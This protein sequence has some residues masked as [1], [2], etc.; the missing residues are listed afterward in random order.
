ML[1]RRRDHA[2][3]GKGQQ[4]CEQDKPS[5]P[6]GIEMTAD[7]RRGAKSDAAHYRALFLNRPTIKQSCAFG[8]DIR[9]PAMAPPFVICCNVSRINPV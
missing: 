4:S 7:N 9:V 3:P 1:V 8:F 5:S 6:T 2:L